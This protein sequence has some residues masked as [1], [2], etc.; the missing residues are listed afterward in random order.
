M[1]DF[2][3]WDKARQELDDIGMLDEVRGIL[4]DCLM[5]ALDIRNI[6][7]EAT[8]NSM[9]KYVSDNSF[10]LKEGVGYEFV[11]D[12]LLFLENPP[13][14]YT[15]KEYKL[16]QLDVWREKI[17]NAREMLEKVEENKIYH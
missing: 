1:G 8:F 3:D 13:F 2:W 6:G 12:L 14:N 15:S 9:Q 11:D 16:E 4:R 10:W 5:Y 7:T 17:R